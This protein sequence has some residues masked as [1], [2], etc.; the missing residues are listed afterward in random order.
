MATFDLEQQEQLDQ[1][2]HF[3]KR[4]GN[5]IT[6][7]LVAVL[8]AYAAWT[9]YLHWQQQRSQGA[10]ALYDELD[11]AAAERN[12]DRVRQAFADLKAQFAGTT[13]AEQGALLSAKVQADAGKQDDARAALQWLVESGKNEGLVAVA[14]L[15]LAGIQLDAKQFDAA[16][17]TLDAKAPEEYAALVADR[18]GDVYLAQGK[19]KEA[20]ESFQAAWKGLEPTIEYRRFVEG[21]LTVLGAPPEPLKAPA[22]S[23][24]PAP[25]Q[26]G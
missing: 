21:K 5:L 17:K 15:R 7:A 9:Y 16:L 2:K 19:T 10:T 6:W 14:R 3:W 24:A 23:T 1:V 18:R 12:T 22:E 4:Y 25:G 11:K 8:G 20:I 26:A 13:A